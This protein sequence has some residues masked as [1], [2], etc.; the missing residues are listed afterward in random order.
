MAVPTLST[1]AEEVRSVLESAELSQEF[2]PA[3]EHVPEIKLK[4]LSGLRVVVVGAKKDKKPLTRSVSLH[5]YE[6]QVAVQKKVA[7]SDIESIDV[8]SA[9]LQE[10]VDYLHGRKL[11]AVM[12]KPLMVAGITIPYVPEHLEQYS[13]FT[14]VGKV[15]IKIGAAN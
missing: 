9:L 1:I 11:D 7:M 4:Q 10:I 3:R 5:E 15:I 2:I 6:V 14:G 8:L 12:E 13:T